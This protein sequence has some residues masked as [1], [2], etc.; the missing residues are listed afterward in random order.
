MLQGTWAQLLPSFANDAGLLQARIAEAV[1]NRFFRVAEDAPHD[2]EKVIYYVH[3]PPRAQPAT[4]AKEVS[5]AAQQVNVG[6]GKSG[7]NVNGGEGK[8]GGEVNGGEVK[9][10]GEDSLEEL[11]EKSIWQASNTCVSITFEL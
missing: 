1:T 8:S 2:A 7:G 5:H 11:G 6:E 9:S 10:G 4:V 3:A